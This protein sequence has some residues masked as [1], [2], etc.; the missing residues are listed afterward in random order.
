MYLRHWYMI[1]SHSLL[2]VM[3]DQKSDLKSTIASSMRCALLNVAGMK[4][5]NFIMNILQLYNQLNIISM[6]YEILH[7][8]WINNIWNCF[9]KIIINYLSSIKIFYVEFEITFILIY[10]CCLTNKGIPN[11]MIRRFHDHFIL[12]N[13]NPYM[14]IIF[15]RQL[16]ILQIQVMYL[17]LPLR[18]C[19]TH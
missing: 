18:T 3:I 19:C 17:K 9:S 5:L 10:R 7:S 4:S 11:I 12:Y 16:R 13:S 2:I 8:N 1:R 14:E 15:S 6:T